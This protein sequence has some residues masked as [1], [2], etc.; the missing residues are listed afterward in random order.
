MSPSHRPAAP[1][2]AAL[3]VAATAAG[4]LVAQPAP[5]RTGASAPSA[6]T[7][8]PSAAPPRPTGQAGPAGQGG[9]AGAPGQTGKPAAPKPAAA[10]SGKPGSRKKAEYKGPT[11]A[12]IRVAYTER[13]E[14]INAGTAQFLDPEAAA[15]LI[16]RLANIDI[17]EC[18]AVEERQDLYLCSVLIESGVGDAVPEF[19]RVELAIVKEKDTWRVQ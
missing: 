6:S 10:Q 18:A 16:I 19:R 17:V 14:T 4:T 13:I 12:D 11:E 3:L 9:Q 1:L 15:K 8:K 2:I 5:E 7:A